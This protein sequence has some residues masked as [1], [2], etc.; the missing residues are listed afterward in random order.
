MPK[1]NPALQT[2]EQS[3]SSRFAILCQETAQIDAE[4][5]HVRF[6]CL[7]TE[8]DRESF[9]VIDSGSLCGVCFSFLERSLHAFIRLALHWGFFV[10]WTRTASARSAERV[11]L[12]R[13][14]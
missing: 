12:T 6:P 1:K 2:L 5:G 7:N 4:R 8:F 3:A 13:D 11:S 9:S 14:A 10:D